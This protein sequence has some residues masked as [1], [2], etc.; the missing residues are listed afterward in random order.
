[1]WSG[2]RVG[3]RAKIIKREVYNYDGLLYAFGCH[4]GYARFQRG[5]MHSR[6]F[7]LNDNSLL[8][9]D[10]ISKES[11]CVARYYIHPSL[12]HVETKGN[13]G[14]IKLPEGRKIYFNIEGAYKV[15]IENTTWH[16]EFGI[17]NINQCIVAYF[18]G[19]CCKMS[20]RWD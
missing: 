17:S 7:S 5:L 14:V 13:A 8:I 10:Q 15:E 9:N 11:N 1:M 20:V 19:Q 18:N 12:K 16:P 6:S 3:A 4:D 2:F